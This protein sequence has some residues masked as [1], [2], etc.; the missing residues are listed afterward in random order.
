MFSLVLF[1]G[2][3]SFV[4]HRGYACFLKYLEKPEAIDVA[5]KSSASQVAFFPLITFC[6]WNKPLKENI[7]KECNLTA[8]DYFKKNMW[9]GQGHANC[10]NPKVLKDQIHYGLDDLWQD[11][12][13]FS[14]STY[15][16]NQRDEYVIYAN[17]TSLQWTSFIEYGFSCHTMTLPVMM[18]ESGILYFAI[19]FESQPSLVLFWHEGGLF[20]TDMPDSC[21]AV[22]VN[23]TGYHIPIGH[24][25][26]ELLE[27]DGENCEKSK[28]YKLDRCR[29]EVI[30]KVNSSKY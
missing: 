2:C 17:D 16:K 10:T 25:T 11:I 18:V 27:Y 12:A 7:L 30:E 22:I 20:Q 14:I 1:L 21:R 23:K 5:F 4:T 8:E 24:E 28:D 9:V 15:E 13:K 6:S 3:A 29:H 19:Y 26:L